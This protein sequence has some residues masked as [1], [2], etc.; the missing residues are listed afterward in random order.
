MINKDQ[1][2]RPVLLFLWFKGVVNGSFIFFFYTLGHETAVWHFKKEKEEI[3]VGVTHTNTGLKD[4][5]EVQFEL[6]WPF[7]TVFKV[8]DRPSNVGA[9]WDGDKE[10]KTFSL[11]LP[12]VSSRVGLWSNTLSQIGFQ[13]IP[14]Q[15]C[16]SNSAESLPSPCSYSLA[17]QS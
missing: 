17:N 12:H 10:N 5:R 8:L 13:G 9:K 15:I 3:T 7:G 6:S 16:H 11:T 2:L 1:I 14:V 4:I